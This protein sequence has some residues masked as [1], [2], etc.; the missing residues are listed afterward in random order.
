MHIDRTPQ[1]QR[2]E[3]L[4]APQ[5]RLRF[6]RS[7]KRH[8]ENT[9]SVGCARA[10]TDGWMWHNAN[11]TTGNLLSMVRVR[12]GEIGVKYTLNDADAD[13]VFAYLGARRQELDA[14]FEWAP[15]WRP[16][17]VNSHVI[18]IRRPGSVL[19]VDSWSEYF[20]WFRRQ[21]ETFQHGLWG[22]V[23]RVPSGGERRQWDRE[24]FVRELRTWNPASLGVA[25]AILDWALT[26]GASVT[27]GSGGQTGSFAPTH[28]RGGF[29]YQLVSV[30]TDGSVVF[31]FRQ[32][33]DSPAFSAR[34]RRLEVLE[35]L[36]QV[37]HFALPEKVIDLRLSLPLAVLM[38]DSA[39]EQFLDVLDWFE[40]TLRSS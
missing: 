9:S 18:E 26:R 10:T 5:L 20:N 6:W 28:P 19:D 24:S 12:L 1:L 32:L 37:E 38:D 8:M 25:N 13:T 15:T 31:L 39:D 35:R 21:L 27:W 34:A 11:L 33:S 4:S 40:D 23:G 7:F 16:G 14:G 30:R 22:L 2:T 29:P 36:N 3:A 17:G